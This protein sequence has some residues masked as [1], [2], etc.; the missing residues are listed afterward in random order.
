M[1]ISGSI[2]KY[3]IP[4]LHDEGEGVNA[5]KTFI[6]YRGQGMLKEE[7]EKITKTKDGLISFTNFYPQVWKKTMQC[8][9][10]DVLFVI[11]RQ[12]VFYLL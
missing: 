12:L 10:P 6:V 3:I 8:L 4:G 5:N 7:F 1:I 2:S 9:L 11:L